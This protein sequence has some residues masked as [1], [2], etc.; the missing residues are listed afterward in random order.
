[1]FVALFFH[2]AVHQVG[3]VTVDHEQAVKMAHFVT[4]AWSLTRV[5]HVRIQDKSYL[6]ERVIIT[7][8]QSPR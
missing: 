2:A 8:N 1:M 6:D 3:Q 5:S 7:V 4:V